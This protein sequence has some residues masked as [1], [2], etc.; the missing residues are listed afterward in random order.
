VSIELII[1]V[2]S[3]EIDIA[4]LEKKKLVELSKEKSNPKFSVG[5]I[6]LGKVRKIMPG[7]NAAFVDV[8]YQKDAFLHYLDLGPQ[9]RSLQKFLDLS[10]SPKNRNISM[11]KMRREK[12][13]DK[14]GKI[15]DVLR[16]GQLILVQIAKEPISTKGPRLTSEI[17]LAGRNSVLIPFN[18]KVSVSQKITSD[19]EKKRLRTLLKSIRPN[20]Y[21]VIVRTVAENK[22]VKVLDSEL[23]GLV[24]KWES[25]FGKIRGASPPSLIISEVNR[26]TAILRDMLNVSFNNIYVN[27]ENFSREIKE[28]ISTI[29]PEKENIVKRYKGTTPIFEK[30]GIEKQIKG[31]FGKTVSFKSGAYLIIEHTEALHVIDVNSGNRSKSVDNQETNA[32]EVNL[33]AV[34]EIARQLRLRDMGGIIVIDF[35]DMHSQENKNKVFERMRKV[36][37]ADRTKHSIL[38]LSKFGLMQITRQRVRPEMEINTRE[39]CPT[40]AGTGEISPSILLVE[41]IENTLAE[42]ME[43][44]KPKQVIL[45]V[46]PYVAAFIEQ[47]FFKSPKRSWQKR[48]KCKIRLVAVSSYDFLQFHFFDGQENKINV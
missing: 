3:K 5:D 42:I 36:M 37:E 9:F 48:Y 7:L 34:D 29:A 24:K 33:A 15:A 4:L 19:E 39:T 44:K 8:G 21:G 41:R 23:R 18:D 14:N 45:K 28:Y 25:A 22:M 6:Y 17:A 30:F 12:D 10:L 26:T 31:S 47:G 40:C 1:N 20:N 2:T 43:V 13:I 35:I 11:Q 46:H 16:N 32:M 27:D 38:P